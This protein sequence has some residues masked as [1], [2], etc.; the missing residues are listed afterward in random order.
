VKWDK[1]DKTE[2]Q[3]S[4]TGKLVNNLDQ[5]M[6]KDDLEKSIN[7]WS[8]GVSPPENNQFRNN[9]VLWH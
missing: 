1:I 5:Q 3:K 9:L 7:N 2:Y 8:S 4:V 6:N